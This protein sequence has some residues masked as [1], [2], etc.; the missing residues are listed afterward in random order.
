MDKMHVFHT[1]RPVYHKETKE[2]VMNFDGKV[3]KSSIKNLILEDRNNGSAKAMLFG[4]IND[5]QYV[6]DVLHPLSP[7]IGIAVAL[8]V[9]D[10][11]MGSD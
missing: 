8:T 3:K 7:L 5:D 9:F 10:S 2:Y 6:L 1:R 11:R 4:K